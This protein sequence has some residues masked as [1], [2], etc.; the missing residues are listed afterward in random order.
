ML[1]KKWPKKRKK[2]ARKKPIKIWTREEEEDGLS[3][4]LKSSL[5]SFTS[6]VRIWRSWR[7]LWLDGDSGSGIPSENNAFF[8]WGVAEGG[9]KS[10]QRMEGIWG[11]DKGEE[12]GDEDEEEEEE[13]RDKS[14]WHCLIKEESCPCDE[15]IP[16]SKRNRTVP[17]V[18]SARWRTPFSPAVV[19]V[20]EKTGEEN[21]AGVEGISATEEREFIGVTEPWE[22][23]GDFRG[24]VVKDIFVCSTKTKRKNKKKRPSRKKDPIVW[25]IDPNDEYKNSNFFSFL[26]LFFRFEL[27]ETHKVQMKAI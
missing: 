9:V 22:G 1:K 13:E 21:W 25:R 23:E 17:G 15:V 3:V 10:S 26:F 18:A 16:T 6:S 20:S 4:E 11:V 5:K 2:I 8:D 12:G 14:F 19:G 24:G 7:S 27:F